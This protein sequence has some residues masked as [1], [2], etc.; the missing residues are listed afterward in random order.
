M[1]T[2]E[3]PLDDVSEPT[4]E[5]EATQHAAPSRSPVFHVATPLRSAVASSPAADAPTP[6]ISEIAGRVVVNDDW[7]LTL[8]AAPTPVATRYPYVISDNGRF[9]QVQLA[10]GSVGYFACPPLRPPTGWLR[11]IPKAFFPLDV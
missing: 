7:S 6:E 5:G 2:F 1:Q 11:K 10:P 4:L 8:I 3:Q 9:I